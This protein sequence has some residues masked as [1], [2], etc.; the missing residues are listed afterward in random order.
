M[1]QRRK[2]FLSI[3]AAVLGLAVIVS[4]VTVTER[5]AHRAEAYG[6][7]SGRYAEYARAYHSAAGEGRSEFG[8]STC[9]G[10]IWDA[11]TSKVMEDMMK[12]HGQRSYFRE[13]AAHYDRLQREYER[14]A[15]QPLRSSFPLGP[16]AEPEAAGPRPPV[17]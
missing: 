16:P 10:E 8:F 7:A 11:Y 6:V 1:L 15:S 3:G 12:R 5:R 2:W 13:R 14:A 4:A 9:Y 17:E